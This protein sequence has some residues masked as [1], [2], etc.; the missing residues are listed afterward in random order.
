LKSASGKPEGPYK[1]VNTP[2][3]PLTRGIDASLFQDDDGS[4]YFLYG[5]GVI[6][7]MNDD[8]TALVTQPMQLACVPDS[9]IEHHHPSRPCTDLA[10]VGFEGVYMFKRNG[11]YYLSCAERY[12]ERYHCMTAEADNLMGP[13]STRYV[14]VPYAGHNVFFQDGG[15]NWWSTI[16][17]ND[18]DAPIQKQAG[19]VPITFDKNGHIIPK[20]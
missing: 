11:R 3:A 5:S 8:M 6:A 4:V 18:P 12:Y 14:S 19:L 13:Y 9:D 16:F 2:D 1:S 10:H 15:N 20:L 7:K 17:G